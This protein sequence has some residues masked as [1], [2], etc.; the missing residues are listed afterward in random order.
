VFDFLFKN[1]A[2]VLSWSFV[3]GVAGSLVV[4]PFTACQLF[5]VLF[6]KDRP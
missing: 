3:L 6:E 2:H 4:I 1:L 5:N